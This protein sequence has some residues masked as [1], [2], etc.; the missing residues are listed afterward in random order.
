MLHDDRWPGRPLLLPGESLSS[1]FARTAVANGL[2]PAELFRIVQPGGDRNPRD[3]DRYADIPLLD[4]LVDRT[5]LERDVL[6]QATIRRWAGSVFAQDDGLNKLPWLPPAGRQGGRRCFGQQFCPSCLWGDR[7]PYLRLIWR[8]SFMAVCPVHG[9]LLL[10]RCPAC[11]EPISVL[12]MDR[13]QE[14]RCPSCAIDLRTCKADAP[15]VA[16]V[17][18]QQDLLRVVGQGWWDLGAYGPVYSF[19][20]LDILSVLVRMLAG[21]PH[22]HALRAWVGGQAPEL[23]VPPEAVCRFLG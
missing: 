20:V 13:V 6:A 15:P 8:L 5:G 21:G 19:A 22:A 1:W 2:R 23:A 4:V 14:M 12:R 7:Q 16:S 3:L 17:P 9:H 18:I 10:D 11:N